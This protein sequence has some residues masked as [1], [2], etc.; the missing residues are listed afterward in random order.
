MKNFAYIITDRKENNLTKKCFTS[1]LKHSDCHLCLY[2]FPES[3]W[4]VDFCNSLCKNNFSAKMIDKKNWVGRRMAYKIENIKSL[5]TINGDRIFI[6]DD[7]LIFQD[8]IYKVFDNDF[9]VCIT[10]R[11][12][13]YW[14]EINGGVWGLKVNEN[15][16]M[17]IDFFIEQIRNPSWGP[18]VDFK[19]RF[20]R[21]SSVDW[22]VDQDFLCTIKNNNL[23]FNCKINDIGYSYNFC[24]SVEE[25]IPSTFQKAKEELLKNVGNKDIKVLHLK[26]R[27]KDIEKEIVV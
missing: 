3:Q 26:G 16:R 19:N 5:N 4:V 7:D 24:P 9:D 17:F 6:L 10:S 15:S 12:Y 27:L 11:H 18:F 8:D 22:W 2:L 25:N 20:S 1:L 21:D 13:N 14:Y 23:P